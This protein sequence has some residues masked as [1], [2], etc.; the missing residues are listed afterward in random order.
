[1]KRLT[2]QVKWRDGQGETDMHTNEMRKQKKNYPDYGSVYGKVDYLRP[3]HSRL[4]REKYPT[5]LSKPLLILTENT[6]LYKCIWYMFQYREH[7]ISKTGL[8]ENPKKKKEE[9]SRYRSTI[10]IFV[11]EVD[12]VLL[13][14][15]W[16]GRKGAASPDILSCQHRT[17]PVRK[18]LCTVRSFCRGSRCWGGDTTFMYKKYRS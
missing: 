12:D 4:A 15:V 17:A 13:K 14:R 16:G 3:R 11:H 7:S 18:S 8:I 9:K 5:F 6:S 10:F 2:D 1:M